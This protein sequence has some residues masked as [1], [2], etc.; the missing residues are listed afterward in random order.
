MTAKERQAPGAP[1]SEP[2]WAPGEKCGVGTALNTACNVWF[3]L[4]H[5]IVSELFYP[6]VDSACTRDLQ[7]L[8]VGPDGCFAE[9][10]KDT[11]WR[12][13]YLAPGVPAFRVCNT[14]KRRRFR[15]EK[16]V[17]ADPHRAAF[18]MKA[19]FE[20]LQGAHADYA[21]YVLL[22]PHL[23]N[24][25]ADNSAWLA[26][27]KGMPMLFAERGGL[28]LALA[29]STPWRQRSV[30]FVGRSDGWQDLHRHGEM[31]WHYERAEN[32]NVALTAQVDPEAARAGFTLAV[33]F[34]AEAG[35]AGHCARAAL[36]QG[37]DDS[38]KT[39]VHA[40][41]E[42]Q[43]G[44]LPLAGSRTHHQ[45]IY[46][47]SAAVMR[48]HEDNHLPGA[49]V[50][51]LAVPW[52]DSRGD[53]HLGYHLVW[54]RDL[55]E[56]V[57]GQ[58]A[59]SQHEDAR[60]VL[61]YMLVTQEPD[62]HWP[63]N[64]WLDGNSWWKG[65]QLDETG[66]VLL[67]VDMLRRE[68]ALTEQEV[69]RRWP[70]LRQ[71]LCYLVQNG[72]VTPMDRWEEV[73][74]Y[75]ASTLAVEIPALLIG[76]ELADLAGEPDVATYLRETADAWN[77]AI[78]PLL[79]V[80]G[81]DL[82]RRV[83]VDG[84]YARFA[85]PDQM[86]ADHPAAGW[87]DLANHPRGKGRHPVA[88]IVSPDAL[89]LVRTGLRA[90]DDP[91]IINTLKVID[92]VLKVD[93][94]GGPCWY[95]YND[96]GYGEHADGSPFDGTGIGRLWPLLTGERAHYELTAGRR[97]EA[98]RLLRA[99]ESFA[100]D[101]GLLPEQVWDVDDIPERGLY[102]GRPSGSAAPLVWAHAEY[103]KLRRSLHDGR[104][105]DTPQH[106]VQRYQRDRVHAGHVIW[107]PD[108]RWRTVPPGK[109]LRLEF[110]EPTAVRWSADGG[111]PSH[112]LQTR[113]TGLGLHMVELPTD[114][115]SVGAR[116]R[117]ICTPAAAGTDERREYEVEVIEDVVWASGAP[118]AHAMRS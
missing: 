66:F 25:G 20:P 52:G 28:V 22:N 75:Y 61:F 88:E 36:L 15:L 107:R 96:D 39:Y 83:G 105:F 112:P 10:K 45:D 27:F 114:H 99:L 26:D 57:G 118:L 74:G 14:C 76:A 82:A 35:D 89:V 9:E 111:E 106:A 84:Y 37:F 65:T 11:D 12:A 97:G 40:W 64:M 54:P 56:T 5:G 19:R 58:L 113:D 62:G 108:Q 91:R 29:C 48:V 17:I 67:L 90:A 30:G 33:G 100:N 43:K 70:L 98:E 63:Q 47:I 92:D 42:W 7:F 6:A 78:E 4:S 109:V 103:A 68:H 32:G 49:I 23:G 87:I 81:T 80:T 31:R 117:F 34:A 86:Q 102:R 116:V 55:I 21:L 16:E 53:D 50:A 18:L 79:Y 71:A 41:S 101:S 85:L 77:D 115:A 94:P 69:L 73:P 51:S 72:P 13:E 8:V 110:R 1:G 95:R 44:L 2:H 38:Q 60:R 59:V 24:H 93:L 104:V 3:T 46:R